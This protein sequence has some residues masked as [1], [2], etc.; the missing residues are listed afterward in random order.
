MNKTKSFGFTLVEL[1]IIIL[2]VGIIAVVVAPR[3][4]TSG[5]NE[6]A[7]LTEF[8]I[9]AKYARHKA[10]VTGNLIGIKFDSNKS[11]SIVDS[12]GDVI[13]LPSSEKNPIEIKGS[14]SYTVDSGQTLTNDTVYFNYMGKPL[15]STNNDDE[16]TGIINININGFNVKI[17]PYSGGIY[18]D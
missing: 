2:I 18:Q 1:V 14:I 9:N 8:I 10:M 17:E 11:Y 15:I 4:T 13:N 7:E 16:L 3:F 12:A 6:S 5:F